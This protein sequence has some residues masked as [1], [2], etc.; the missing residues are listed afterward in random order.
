MY[1]SRGFLVRFG[2]SARVGDGVG[3]GQRMAGDVTVTEVEGWMSG[4]EEVTW[5]ISPRFVRPEPRA[6]AGAYLRGL[7]SGAE[8]KNAG[9]LAE[10]AGD[11]TPDAMQRLLNAAGPGS[12]GRAVGS[13][14]R[15]PLPSGARSPYS[16]PALPAST[17]P[18][19]CRWSWVSGGSAPGLWDD[20]AHDD[21]YSA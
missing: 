4:L 8:R 9:Q 16:H 19:P 15:P 12:R 17:R 3:F 10:Q 18:G 20:V 5:R 14:A 13:L 21:L 2:V 6:Q 7:L 11:A 1:Y